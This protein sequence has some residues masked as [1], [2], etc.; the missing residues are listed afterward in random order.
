[1]YTAIALIALLL[2][3][4]TTTTTSA[5]PITRHLS[6]RGLPG[7]YYTCTK[8]NFAGDC[9]WTQPNT[10]CHIQGSPGGIASIGPDQGTV[11]SLFKT[12][13]CTGESLKQVTFPGIAINMPE[14]GSFQCSRQTSNDGKGGKTAGQAGTL[15]N[16][17]VQAAGLEIGD[18]G[19]KTV[20]TEGREQGMIGLKKG[21]YY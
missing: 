21:V 16:A 3:I 2:T 13:V 20:K 18:F 7:A 11:C 1:M 5:S 10:E 9:S 15:T 6:R 14:I 19:L 17:D 4:T 8:P 12:A